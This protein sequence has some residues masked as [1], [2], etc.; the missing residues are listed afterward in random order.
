[1][2][3]KIKSTFRAIH[4]QQQLQENDHNIM[5]SLNPGYEIFMTWVSYLNI[6]LKSSSIQSQFKWKIILL[7]IYLIARCRFI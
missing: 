3:L 5:L 6:I 1:M 2:Y 7:I 4:I